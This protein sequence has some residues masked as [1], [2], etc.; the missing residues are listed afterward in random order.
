MK[1]RATLLALVGA[2]GLL[3]G[4]GPSF[5]EKFEWV[6]VGADDR[7]DVRQILGQPKFRTHDQWVYDKPKKHTAIIY[8]DGE[9]RVREKEW[10]DPKTGEWQGKHPDADEPPAG[11][12]RE[13]STKTR[14]IDID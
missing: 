6:K 10:I 11:E 14:R 5:R 7:E 13:R 8:F 4:C 12:V 9:G 2:A 3:L 1:L